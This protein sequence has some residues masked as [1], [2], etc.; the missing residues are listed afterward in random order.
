[1]REEDSLWCGTRDCRLAHAEP[2]LEQRAL[3]R[4]QEHQA[5]HPAHTASVIIQR[6]PVHTPSVIQQAPMSGTPVIQRA[7]VI[8]APVTQWPPANGTPAGSSKSSSTVHDARQQPGVTAGSALA[9]SAP[10]ALS[11]SWSANQVAALRQELRAAEKTVEELKRMLREA[12]L[13]LN[14]GP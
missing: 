4:K 9:A 14:P 13:T 7:Q 1:M 2:S 10:A 11:A 6:P 12:E 3:R 5:L 8:G